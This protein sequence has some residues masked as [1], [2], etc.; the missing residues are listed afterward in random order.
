MRSITVPPLFPCPASLFS[1]SLWERGQNR[2]SEQNTYPEDF[3]R[4][5]SGKQTAIAADGM[6]HPGYQQGL[7]HHG[8]GTGKDR[9][10]KVLFQH[11]QHRERGQTGP[12][13]EYRLCLRDINLPRQRVGSL[14][15]FVLTTP[16]PEGP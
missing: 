3:S 10:A 15:G 14:W 7:P 12:T 6:A 9:F 13:Q 2:D 11:L 4:S 8:R 5:G 16:R 1:L